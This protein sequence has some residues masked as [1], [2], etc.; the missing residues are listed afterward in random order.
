M[1]T[2]KKLSVIALSFML[3]VGFATGAMASNGKGVGLE[4]APGQSVNFSKGITTIVT[5]TENVTEDVLVDVET[6]SDSSNETKTSTSV[7]EVV[8]DV[9]KTTERHPVQNWYREV[10]TTTT[11]TITTTSSWNETTTV[12][13]T[14]TTET[15]VTITET[16]VTTLSH[17]GAPGSNGKVISENSVTTNGEVL[18]DAIVNTEY[19]T[20]VSTGEVTT[21]FTKQSKVTITTGNWIK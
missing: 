16:T 15:P 20:T 17:R 5:T 7:E 4:T 18:G 8:S 2:S 10:F 13:T 19:D 21:S 12:T 11:D 1:R 3:S 14:T 6:S 9:I